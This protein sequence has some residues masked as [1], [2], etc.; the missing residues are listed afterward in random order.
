MRRLFRL[1][2]CPETYFVLPFL[3][4]L[5]FCY[6]LPPSQ[7]LRSD[8]DASWQFVLTSAF[9]R[10]SQFGRDVMFTYGPWSFLAEPRG[11]P[12]I[13]PWLV[14]GR[15]LLACALIFGCARIAFDRLTTWR[16]WGWMLAIILLANPVLVLPVLLLALCKD[17]L[18]SQRRAGRAIVALLVVACGLTAWVKFTALIL[19][20]A[21]FATL[22]AHDLIR[23]RRPLV[24]VGLLASM[25]V[26]WLLAGQSMATLPSYL[27]SGLSLSISYSNA[28]ASGGENWVWIVS[29]LYCLWLIVALTIYLL[30]ARDWRNV[31]M[32]VWAILYIFLGFKQAFVRQDDFHFW[33]GMF[34]AILPGTLIILGAGGCIE[35]SGNLELR[36]G[37]LRSI[38]RASRSFTLILGGVFLIFALDR[39]TGRIHLRQFASNVASVFSQPTPS[40][41]ARADA[42]EREIL[43]R[44]D[45]IGPVRG[46]VDFFPDN[47]AVLAANRIP[48]ELRPEP[49]AYSAYNKFL[50]SSNA[51]RLRSPERPD[52]VVFDIAPID[53]RYPTISDSL[54]VLSLLSCYKPVGFTGRYLLLSS[55]DCIPISRTLLVET[56]VEAGKQ[57]LVPKIDSPIWV[58]IE[59]SHSVLETVSSAFLRLPPLQL[60]IDTEFYRKVFAIPDEL[61]SVGFLLSPLVSDPISFAL[62]SAGKTDSPSDIR[63]IGVSRGKMAGRFLGRRP[64]QVRLYAVSIPTRSDVNNI[65]PPLMLQLARTARSQVGL[66]DS[67]V[68]P[69]WYISAGEPRLRVAT[70]STARIDVGP[71]T[72]TLHLRWGLQNRCDPQEG[73]FSRVRFSVTSYSSGTTVTLLERTLE[74]RGSNEATEEVTIKLEQSLGQLKFETKPAGGTCLAEAWWSDVRSDPQSP[75]LAR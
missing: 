68:T 61:G 31:P 74:A 58:Q 67:A 4:L 9:L 12:G 54:S 41:R 17:R 52:S 44:A 22:L 6:V 42:L 56:T 60:T 18:T 64:I 28:M 45:P 32:F 30:E 43:R 49:Q 33:F 51:S 1:G 26:F 16:R 62:L 65:V 24:A 15:L 19:V 29:G 14:S 10:G 13:Y 75:S 50:T 36:H 69:A 8:V 70:A 3:L 57:I 11:N 46:T 20:L 73:R 47:I 7:P 5:L 2:L 71:L 63:A 59:T 21:L 25:I 72:R 38:G 37:L 39:P 40:R 35:G 23:Q 55:A 27:H 66:S 34:G 53:E 48:M